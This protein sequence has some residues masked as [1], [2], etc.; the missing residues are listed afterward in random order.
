MVGIFLNLLLVACGT[1]ALATAISFFIHENESG[2]IRLY[3][4]HFGSAIFLICIG[5]AIM[6]FT[7]DLNFA[8]IPR[9]FGLAGIDLFLIIELSFLIKE[10]RIRNSIHSLIL[11]CF[12]LYFLFDMIIFGNKN[13]LNYVRFETYTAYE[14]TGDGKFVFHYLFIL[15]LAFALLYF[16][17]KWYKSKKIRRDKIFALE[18]IGVNFIVIFATIPDVMH[19]VFSAKY[20]TISYSLSLGLVYFSWWFAC[21]WHITYRP[22]VKNVSRQVYDTLDIPILIF[23]MDGN[24]CIQNPCATKK[25]NIA[26]GTH[27]KLRDLFAFTDVE[28]MLFLKNAREGIGE[29]TSVHM[30]TTNQLCVLTTNVQLDNAGEPFC[31]IGAVFQGIDEQE[32]LKVENL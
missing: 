18:V 4:L 16:G 29:K 22:N 27:P 11:G 1:L 32:V 2:Y 10:L 6:A 13:A 3:T 20:P 19:T 5:Y 7:Q 8:Y 25:F 23:D 14:N 26:E 12:I 31:I 15:V 30:K 21:R 9:F 24:V 17:I 28:T